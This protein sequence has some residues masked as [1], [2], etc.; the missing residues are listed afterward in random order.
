MNREQDLMQRL[1]VSKKIM[2]KHGE[3]SRN[4]IREVNDGIT[5]DE[6]QPVNAKYNLPE[7]FMTEQKQI[8]NNFDPSKPI[9]EEKF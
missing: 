9:E 4:T 7:E 5:V 3:M 1:A 2:Q 6:Y 8:T